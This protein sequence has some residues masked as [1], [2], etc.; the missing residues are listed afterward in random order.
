G[1]TVTPL[2]GPKPAPR[3]SLDVQGRLYATRWR[4]ANG[5]VWRYAGGQWTRRWDNAFV[6]AVASD[7]NDPTRLAVAT[8]DNPDHDVCSAT[9]VWVSADDGKTWRQANDGLPVLRGECIAFD[10][11]TPGRMVLGTHG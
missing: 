6:Y 4:E 2:G 7:P 1:K 10:P 9:G 8:D 5:G 11:H 3:I